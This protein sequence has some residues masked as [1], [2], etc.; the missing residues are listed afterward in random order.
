MSDAKM[1]YYSGKTAASLAIGFQRRPER[2]N[3]MTFDR[4][5]SLHFGCKTLPCRLEKSLTM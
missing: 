3:T 5:A 4:L 1:K 2:M